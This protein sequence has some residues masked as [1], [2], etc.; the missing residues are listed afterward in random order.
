MAGGQT[1]RMNHLIARCAVVFF[2]TVSLHAATVP[3]K[4]AIAAGDF[5]RRTTV[6]TLQWPEAKEATLQLV[7][8]KNETAVLQVEPSG[9]ATF[10]EREL[11]KG[12]SKTYQVRPL[13]PE[14]VSKV[15]LTQAAS[16][17]RA[18][19]ANRTIL[20]YQTTPSAVPE[21]VSAHY[22][23][24]AYL[25]PVFSPTGKLVTADYPPDHRHQRGIFFGWTKT[26]F[27]GRHPDYWNMGKGVDGKFTGEVRFD[28]VERTWSGAVHGGL[29]SHHRWLDHTSGA[30]KDVLRETWELTA[31]RPTG[32]APAVHVFDLT[33]TQNCAGD[34]PLK[35]PMYHYGGLGVRGSAVWDPVD[36]VSMLTSEGHDRKAGDAK[37]AKWVWLGGEVDGGPTG[38]AVLIH[39]DNFRFPQPLRLNP[40]NPQ[41]CV[42]PSQDGDWEIAPGK[43]YVS[44]Y[45]F[46]IFDGKPD[47][48][49]L[50]RLWNDYAKPPAVTVK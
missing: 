13:A 46:A 1:R 17:V 42:A 20:Q 36:K 25:H 10:I 29:V 19:Y 50:E 40:K 27:E 48:A 8:A 23:H 21:G 3:T 33:S 47:A 16:N 44:R 6:V 7:G 34:A 35:L 14:K 45:R 39:P 37:K 9:R 32:G 18:A 26:E 49:E 31:V 43:P 11:A 2:A 41:L 28:S 12:A 30:E 24:G 5:D 4:L 22:G 38:I 15:T